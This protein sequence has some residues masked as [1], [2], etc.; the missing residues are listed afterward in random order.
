AL[1]AGSALV[2]SAFA[3][4]LFPGWS[5]YHSWQYATIS[6][7]LAWVT[8]R[9]AFCALFGRDGAVG[10]GLAW[11]AGGGLLIGLAGLA[12]GLLGPDTQSFVRPP[13][14]VQTSPDLD[15]AVSFPNVDP[16]TMMLSDAA[17]TLR[18][19][20][21]KLWKLRS[22]GQLWKGSALIQALPR[23]AVFI[24][25]ANAK[26]ERVTV[27]Q[28]DGAAFL[29][30][31]LLFPQTV[32]I[33][34]ESLPSDAFAVPALDREVKAILFSESDLARAPRAPHA[35]SAV[36]FAVETMRTQVL[37]PG[38]IGFATSGE[39]VRL[40]GVALH[41]MIGTYPAL[42]LSS[43]PDQLTFFVGVTFVVIG[44]GAST[45]IRHRE[46]NDR[47]SAPEVP[48]YSTQRMDAE[49]ASIGT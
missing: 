13:G 41:A 15:L 32:V 33:G 23:P 9:Y 11:S 14:M 26:G 1:V 45:V 47:A 37:V 35:S 20:G 4:V 17:L 18:D 10:R 29:S 30:P 21:G 40:G 49:D 25:A 46:R 48:E 6:V 19:H 5:G 27:T 3:Q 22:G 12:S 16:D 36:L 2:L 38:S 24:E 8:G 42:A 28:P 44:I 31:V 43:A 39:R 34:G 7:I